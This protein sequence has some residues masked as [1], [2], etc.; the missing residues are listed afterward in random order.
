MSLYELS[1]LQ[2]YLSF[3]FLIFFI[4]KGKIFT[5]FEKH[6][7]LTTRLS[8]SQGGIEG[9]GSLSDLGR[10]ILWDR[11]IFFLAWGPQPDLYESNDHY[12]SVIPDNAQILHISCMYAPPEFKDSHLSFS[13]TH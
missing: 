6:K 3:Y 10:H 8:D 11:R 5:S 13:S 1:Q 9:P 7:L 2:I 4:E 12:T